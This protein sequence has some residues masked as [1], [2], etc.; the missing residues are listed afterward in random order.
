M[1]EYIKA[2]REA[3]YKN[4]GQEKISHDP[5][6]HNDKWQ[7]L[8]D[9]FAKWVEK[10]KG[11]TIPKRDL[12]RIRV[13]TGDLN[14]EPW[15]F[16]SR[17]DAI[18]SA[19]YVKI[20]M[21]S[22]GIQVGVDFN[23]KEADKE[24][25]SDIYINAFRKCFSKVN[26]GWQIEDVKFSI[27][28]SIKYKYKDKEN[29]PDEDYESDFLNL[30][31]EAIKQ[32]E[33][34]VKEF[35]KIRDI[36]NN[37]WW[38]SF[39][40]IA[41]KAK[42][43][44][45][46][47]QKA[48]AENKAAASINGKIKIVRVKYNDIFLGCEEEGKKYDI[49][50]DANTVK[51]GLATAF[52]KMGHN[53]DEKFLSVFKYDEK[54]QRGYF[55]MEKGEIVPMKMGLPL[56]LFFETIKEVFD[57]FPDENTKQLKIIFRYLTEE[58]MAYMKE[59]I[60]EENIHHVPHNRI[61]FG[62]PG[63]GKSWKI[64]NESTIFEN[65]ITRVTFHPEY[66]YYDFVGSYKPV[67]TG[68]KIGYGFVPGPFASILREALNNPDTDYCL[69]IEEINRARVAAVFGDIFQ[70]LDR[71]KSGNSEYRIKPSK[72]LAHYL[73]TTG[74]KKGTIDDDKLKEYESNGIHLT[75]N[76]YIWAT[77][78]SA[79]QGVYPLDTAFKR[80]WSME[81]LSINEG[82]QNDSIGWNTIRKGIN[83]LLKPHVNEDKL[84][85]YYFLKEEE[86]DTEEHLKEALAGKVLMYLFDDAAKPC[87][88]AVFKEI[89]KARIYSDLREKMS[90]SE[91]NLGIFT[92]SEFWPGQ[93]EQRAGGNVQNETHTE[94][95][96]TDVEQ[97]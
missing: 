28:K 6:V 62:A 72:E 60:G 54:T 35:Q 96:E 45:N 7:K 68:T 49:C 64:K 43:I 77:M 52:S 44:K 16:L 83:D 85:G 24:K 84:M 67:M 38:F 65:R 34:V 71:D 17:D 39:D 23:E 4:E 78:N 47:G 69:I 81:Y 31:Q 61:V 88:K 53:V 36:Y 42:D 25:S 74:D 26:D 3:W 51:A 86:R 18:K 80:R 30:L 57:E 40:K 66:S 79:D 14:K 20:V 70:L 15:L 21:C 94:E 50:T 10:Q 46:E 76:L 9:L 97:Q 2:F 19:I 12:R 95:A 63:T 27:Y 33:I 56:H 11:Y 32:Y 29:A 92:G 90:L 55:V 58:S 73:A 75:S 8:Y 48:N 91:S 37:L 1:S 87:R 89:N 5:D 59:L 41:D 82:A 22:D 13:R 93:Q